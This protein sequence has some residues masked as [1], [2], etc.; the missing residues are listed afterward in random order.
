MFKL[1]SKRGHSSQT[2]TDLTEKKVVSQLARDFPSNPHSVS[3]CNSFEDKTCAWRGL[4][5]HFGTKRGWKKLSKSTMKPCVRV[6]GEIGFWLLQWVEINGFFR[7]TVSQ[8]GSFRWKKTTLIRYPQILVKIV[9]I[10][11][12]TSTNLENSLQM[13]PWYRFYDLKTLL[14]EENITVANLAQNSKTTHFEW[15]ILFFEPSCP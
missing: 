1:R 8:H 15:T 11:Q 4:P 12:T 5:E 13:S 10:Y 6:L 2:L 7:S 9:N 14:F 3:C